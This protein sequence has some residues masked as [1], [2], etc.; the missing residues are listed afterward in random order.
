VH[1]AEKRTKTHV[2]LPFDL[3]PY[4]LEV[5]LIIKIQCSSKISLS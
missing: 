1:R 5:Q 3:G 2:T 4:D